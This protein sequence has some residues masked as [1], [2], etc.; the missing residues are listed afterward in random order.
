MTTKVLSI[1]LDYIMGPTIETYQQNIHSG[2]PEF[3]WKIFYDHHPEHERA[4]YWIDQSNLLYCYDI[5]LKSLK[6]NPDV[7]FGYDHDAILY[8]IHQ[9]SDIELINVDHHDDVMHGA[10]E[11]GLG[12]E[13]FHVA[14]SDYVCEGNW[15]AWLD[16]K[17]RLKSFTWIHN[18]NS[19]NLERNGFNIDLLG[20]KYHSCPRSEYKFENYKF[21]YVYVCLSPHYIA[22]EQWHYFTMFMMAYRE[23]TGNDIN[24]LSQQRF[25][26]NEIYNKVSDAIL[27]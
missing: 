8:A 25:E 11:E 10:H 22:Q 16:H 2:P 21:D 3:S 4:Y 1:D 9:C 27:H 15:G 19:G 7:S 14:N 6:Y 12:W 18:N 24:L 20:D 13:N 5:F 17:K 26:Y 23:F